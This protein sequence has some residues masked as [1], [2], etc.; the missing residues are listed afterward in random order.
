VLGIG[1]GTEPAAA[2][3][4]AVSEPVTIAEASGITLKDGYLYIVD[5]SEGSGYF[6]I[7]VP[8]DPGPVIDL[9]AH[10]PERIELPYG[11]WIDLESIGCLADGRLVVLS[12]RLRGLVCDT[13]PVAEYDYPLTEFGR[14]GL[15]GMAIRPL[16]DGGSRV[17]VLWEGGYADRGSLHP[18]V[19]DRA[20][21]SAL[22]PVLFVHDIAA[23][24]S[25]G[26][27]RWKNAVH[28]AV[29]DVPKPA[30]EEPEAQRFRAPALVWHRI[31]GAEPGEWGFIVVLS[32][33]NG[34]GK[35]EFL[36][37]WLQRF[38]VDGRPVGS[39]IHM[40]DIAPADMAHANWEG[41]AWWEEGQTLIMVHE[42]IGG[43]PPRALIFPLPE[44]WR[45]P[46]D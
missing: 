23:G 2:P 28:A 16:P 15:E 32:S 25:V 39:P 26:R 30:G 33:Q 10:N 29:L 38:D 20:G 9:N 41:I 18:Q 3:A 44:E 37:H 27:V 24:A 22:Q 12:E 8:D 46:A 21:E 1:C 4:G 31:P 7:R 11:P 35:L 42:G 13:G 43:D 17:A 14:R 36:H 19:V 6:R 5:D 45:Y 40:E 34:A